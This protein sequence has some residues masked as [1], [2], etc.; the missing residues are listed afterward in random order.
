MELTWYQ[1]FFLLGVIVVCAC[2]SY[3]QYKFA[4]YANRKNWGFLGKAA[5]YTWWLPLI[6]AFFAVVMFV[7]AGIHFGVGLLADAISSAESALRHRV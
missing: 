1:A 2:W 3:A 4:G 6:V 7:L 5:H